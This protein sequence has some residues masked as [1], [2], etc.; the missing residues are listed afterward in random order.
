MARESKKDKAAWEEKTFFD[1]AKLLEIIDAWRGR[2]AREP[3]SWGPSTVL[4]H[5]IW[6]I[7][8]PML[9]DEYK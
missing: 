6:Q 5:K 9:K 2:A 7:I 4:A 1:E 3:R 8:E